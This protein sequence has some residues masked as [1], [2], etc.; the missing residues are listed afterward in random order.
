MFPT[1]RL[2]F[3]VR[4]AFMLQVLC[5][6]PLQMLPATR[7]IESLFFEPVSDPPMSRKLAKTGDLGGPGRQKDFPNNSGLAKEAK[8]TNL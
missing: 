5:S 1:P 8:E 7:L 4:F 2:V 3:A 6:F